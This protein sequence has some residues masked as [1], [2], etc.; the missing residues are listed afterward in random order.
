MPAK[1][2]YTQNAPKQNKYIIYKVKPKSTPAI[3]TKKSWPKIS[4]HED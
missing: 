3:S 4:D 1:Q 2:Y